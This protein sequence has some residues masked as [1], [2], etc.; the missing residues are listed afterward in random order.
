MFRLTCDRPCCNA[1]L[2]VTPE[3]GMEIDELEAKW[4]RVRVPDSKLGYDLCPF[5]GI[6][7][8]KIINEF[9]QRSAD[10]E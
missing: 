2:E 6:K 10:A 3:S 1:I 8:A 9:L 4:H 5:C 7:W